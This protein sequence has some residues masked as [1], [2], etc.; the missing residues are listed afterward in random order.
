[1]SNAQSKEGFTIV[2]PDS[3]KNETIYTYKGPDDSGV[4]H[5][6]VVMVDTELETQDLNSYAQQRIQAMMNTLN[7]F[8]LLGQ[9]ERPLKSG[10]GA[11]EAVFK[12]IPTEGKVIFQKQVYLISD[13]KGY[14]FTASFSKKT[15][16]T[17]GNDVDAII[18]SFTPA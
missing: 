3:W 10:L 5:N 13:G 1:M 16:K 15:L 9:R 11:Y 12:W 6:L 14:N 4:Q 7:G 8:E 2:L 18:D 17:I